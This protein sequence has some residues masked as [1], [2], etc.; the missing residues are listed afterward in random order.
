VFQGRFKYG[1][2]QKS[3]CFFWRVHQETIWKMRTT[4]SFFASGVYCKYQAVAMSL[5]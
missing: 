3:M 2:H 5:C 1:F 4:L